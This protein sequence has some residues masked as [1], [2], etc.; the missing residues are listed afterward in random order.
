MSAKSI[1]LTSLFS[2]RAPREPGISLSELA[3]ADDPQLTR[4]V[5]HI[6]GAIQ[7]YAI[8]LFGSHARGQGRVNSNYDV[9]A[10]VADDASS[11][12]LHLETTYQ[13]A[14]D[15]RVPANIVTCR[16]SAFERWRDVVGTL[17][18]EASHHGIRVY[19][20]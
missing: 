11:E 2:K 9:F 20:G 10:V 6:V 19:G 17:S 7:P 15:V 4:L 13:L 14:R 16:K 3:I 1:R 12:R 5:D 18:Y 8:Y